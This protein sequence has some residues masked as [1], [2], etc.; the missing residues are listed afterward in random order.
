MM[1]H[2]ETVRKVLS[3]RTTSGTLKSRESNTVEFKESFNKNSTAKYAKTMAA[4]SNNRGGYI[5]FGVKDNPRKI[6]GLRNNNF[7]N[8]S[9]EQFSE[10]INSL[11]APAMD[12]ECGTLT[13]DIP[14]PDGV[15]SVQPMKIGWIYTQEAEYKPVIA[16]KP[17]DGEKINSGDVYYRY[18]ARSEKIKFAEMSRIIEDRTAKEREGLLRLFEVIRESKTANLGIVNYTNG[19]ITTPYGVDVAFDRKLV[20][21]V[22]RKA[23]F[24]KEGSFNE[25]EGIPVIKVT[26]NIDLA[27]EVPVPE[28]NPD[29]THP[30]IQRQLAEKLN[31][32]THD[33]YALIWYYKM[34]EAKK[35]HLEITVSRSSVTHKFSEFAFQFLEAKLSELAQ[36]PEEFDK[37]RTAYKNRNKK[38]TT[39]EMSTSIKGMEVV[40]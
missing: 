18:R 20:T 26:G 16:Q 40:E 29:E 2:E 1:S 4:F 35:Y 5:I 17:N 21:Q 15:E 11:F 13:I 27:E 23:K 3:G 12:W 10:A 28:G 30:Y 9:Q 33:L 38:E 8:M 22:L 14:A 25:T 34:K 6:I 36:K 37:I 32:S 24:I 31:I 19:K 39:E 7:E